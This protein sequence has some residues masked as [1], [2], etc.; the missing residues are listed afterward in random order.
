MATGGPQL[1][2]GSYAEVDLE[3]PLPP[4]CSQRF[5]RDREYTNLVGCRYFRRAS[6]DGAVLSV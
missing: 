1:S 5:L 6:P 2:G 3:L 4:W